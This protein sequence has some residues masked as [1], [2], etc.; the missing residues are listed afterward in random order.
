VYPNL[1]VYFN[2]VII[3][4]TKYASFLKELSDAFLDLGVIMSIQLI[5]ILGQQLGSSLSGVRPFAFVCH[6]LPIKG[7]TFKIFSFF[8][9]SVDSC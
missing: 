5:Y 6:H 4:K 9:H 1:C 7:I 3:S 2:Q 8:F